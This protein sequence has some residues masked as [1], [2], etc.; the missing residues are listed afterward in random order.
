[1]SVGLRIGIGYDAHRFAPGRDLVLGGVNIPFEHG[2][3]GHSDADVLSHALMDALLGAARAKDIGHH[4]PDTDE[5]FA[6]ASSIMLLE[7]V[8]AIVRGQGFEI[9]DADCV[10]QLEKPKIARFR[11]EMRAQLA[12]AMGVPLERVG[13]KATTTEGLGFVGRQEG[14]AAQAVVLLESTSTG[15]TGE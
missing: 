2:L 1:M 15:S 10:L 12:H 5:A 11:E 4:F 3:L 14:V 6:G 13:L 9:V 7:K 8:A